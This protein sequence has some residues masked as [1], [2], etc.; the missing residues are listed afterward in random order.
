MGTREHPADAAAAVVERLATLLGHGVAPDAAWQYVAQ[1][2]RAAR[3]GS[4]RSGAANR[5]REPRMHGRRVAHILRHRVPEVPVDVQVATALRQGGSATDVLSQQPHAPWRALG[6]VWLLANR[7]GA[8]LGQVLRQMAAGFRDLGQSARDV[9]VA[10]AGPASASRIVLA[11]PVLGLL[12][13][14]ALG[15]DTLS[16]FTSSLL[17]GALF[18]AGMLLIVAGWWW[19]RSLVRRA[20]NRP[21]TPGL[22][23]DLVAMGMLSGRGADEVNRAV[24]QVMRECGLD[25]SGYRQAAPI[26]ALAAHAG[27]PAAA[28]L[29]A[30]ATLARS[31]ARTE[32]ASA[33]A[34]LGVTLMLPLGAC[35]LPAFLVLGVAPLVIAVLQQAVLV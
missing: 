19:N 32:A 10:L 21:Q 33:A 4:A 17:G 23:L 9:Q 35:I 28:L 12:L 2:S 20:T 31:R 16:I 30:E 6:A 8:P 7:T 14:A 1:S 18:M 24:A 34:K 13:G 15:F 22:G 29:Q 25:E 26:L 5:R 11:L 3:S 27:V